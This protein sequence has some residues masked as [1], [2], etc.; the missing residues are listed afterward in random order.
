MP[1]RLTLL[2]VGCTRKPKGLGSKPSSAKRNGPERFPNDGG[3]PNP[4]RR[5]LP[6]GLQ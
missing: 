2:P 4:G 1:Q 3:N 5:R 6:C